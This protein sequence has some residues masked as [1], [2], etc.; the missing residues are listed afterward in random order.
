MLFELKEEE[1]I[2]VV[3]DNEIGNKFMVDDYL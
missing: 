3:E 2:N 1:I